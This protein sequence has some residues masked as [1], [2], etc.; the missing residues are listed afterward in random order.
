MNRLDERYGQTTPAQD[1]RLSI[2]DPGVGWRA[3]LDE[4]EHYVYV[5]SL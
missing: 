3:T 4:D 5:I 1:G 2:D